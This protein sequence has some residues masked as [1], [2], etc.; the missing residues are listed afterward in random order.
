MSSVARSLGI[1]NLE[2]GAL[3]GESAADDAIDAFRERLPFP[4]IAETVEGAWADNV[5]QGDSAL[6]PAYIAAARR[7]VARGAIAISANCGYSVRHQAAVA[8]AVNV[9]VAA[10]SLI[11]LP[12]LLRQYPTTAKI[13]VIAADSSCKS[14]ADLVPFVQRV[15]GERVGSL[16]GK[17]LF[18]A[19]CNSRIF[20]G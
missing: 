3:A 17:Y 6:E 7:L 2:R 20:K 19:F 18:V 11:L 8:S 13:A 14:G 10:T 1:L 16:G 12:L 5:I 15:L 4:V 9:P